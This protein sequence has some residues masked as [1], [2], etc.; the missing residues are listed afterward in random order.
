MPLDAL[1]AARPVLPWAD[2]HGNTVAIRDGHI[3]LHLATPAMTA[4]SA[5]D[6][7]A[8]LAVAVQRIAVQ[9]INHTPTEGA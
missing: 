2:T 3:H 1:L 6:V 5:L 8:A 9:R 7:S 4:G